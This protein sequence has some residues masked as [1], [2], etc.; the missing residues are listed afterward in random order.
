MRIFEP[1]SHAFGITVYFSYTEKLRDH[2]DPVE[3]DTGADVD[4]VEEEA[5]ECGDGGNEVH[6]QCGDDGPAN[7]RDGPGQE[8][9]DTYRMPRWYNLMY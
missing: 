8:G 3:N 5:E 7:G 6:Q 2:D 4:G 9:R 1:R